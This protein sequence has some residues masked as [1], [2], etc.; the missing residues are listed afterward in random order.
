MKWM[1]LD[2]ADGAVAD[3][4]D[5]FHLVVKIVGGMTRFLVSK[6]NASFSNG[7]VLLVGSGTSPD[8]SSAMRAA[9]CFAA[10]LRVPC[11]EQGADGRR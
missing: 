3:E 11:P 5:G 4:S 6:T 8:T 10:R 7:D 1:W 2:D 9:E